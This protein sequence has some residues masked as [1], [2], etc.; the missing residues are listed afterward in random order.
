METPNTNYIKQLAG[1]DHDFAMQFIS[2]LKEEFPQEREEY[3]TTLKNQEFTKTAEIVHKIK[4]KFNIL[5]LEKSYQLAQ[6][7]EADLLQNNTEKGSDF[8][9]VLDMVGAYI[10]KL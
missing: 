7:F 5:G 1:D 9:A 8:E 6:A 2:I 3:E 10:T 4:H